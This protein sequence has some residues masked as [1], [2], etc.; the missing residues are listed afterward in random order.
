[1]PTV[2]RKVNTS[3]FLKAGNLY[4]SAI[5]HETQTM[6]PVGIL[7]MVERNGRNG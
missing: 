4:S 3:L 5:D 1:M 2:Q 7:A 6:I